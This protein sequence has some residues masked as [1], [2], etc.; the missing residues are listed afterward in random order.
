MYKRYHHVYICVQLCIGM[1][2]HVQLCKTDI[3]HL[4]EECQAKQMIKEGEI[5]NYWENFA[6]SINFHLGKYSSCAKLTHAKINVSPCVVQYGAVQC[7]M[8]QCS[9][10]H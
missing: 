9:T 10:V 1:T 8:A 6:F 2:S 7:I 3:K 5:I 4:R